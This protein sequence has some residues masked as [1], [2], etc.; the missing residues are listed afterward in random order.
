MYKKSST[1]HAVGLLLTGIFMAV[2]VSGCNLFSPQKKPDV[3]PPNPSVSLQAEPQI[4]VYMHETG[5]TQSMMMEDYI[6]GVVAGE[7]KSD[8]PVEALAAQAILARTFTIEAIETKGGVPERHTQA[9][10]DIKEF[11]AYS[12]KDI[13]DNVKQAVAMTRGKII[14]YQGQPIHAWFHASAGGMT[15]TAKEGLDY[16]DAEPPYIMAVPSPDD[17]APADIKSWTAKV[18]KQDILAAMAK[19]GQT[20][21]SLDSIEVTQKGPSGRVTQFTV[22][23]SIPV[24]GP[25]L[26]VTVG[27][28]LIKSML[29]DKVEIVG[30]EVSFTGKGYGHGVG[31][32]QWGAYSLAKSGKTANEIIAQ[33]FKDVTIEQR[34]Q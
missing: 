32:S 28:T 7:M 9:S 15:A 24:S 20:A 19:L 10:T 17:L 12:A 13:T 34:Y 31:M 29:L 33:Y 2:A 8:W 6:A 11:Q 23:K 25:E 30:D 14:T 3:T 18:K 27:G 4:S 26:R 16:K 5:T 22:N 21:S 1:I